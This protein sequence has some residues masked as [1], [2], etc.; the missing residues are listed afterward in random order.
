MSKR[1]TQKWNHQHIGFPYHWVHK[2]QYEDRKNKKR[3]TICKYTSSFGSSVHI[4]MQCR[5]NALTNYFVFRYFLCVVIC[6]YVLSYIFWCPLRMSKRATQKWNHQH[7][8]F[9]YHWVHKTQYEDRKNK[10]RNTICVGHHNTPASTKQHEPSYKQ[11]ETEHCFYVE[12]VMDIKCYIES[13]FLN[14]MESCFLNAMESCFLNAMES[15]FLNA[16]W[17]HV[18]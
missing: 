3:N 12:I 6:L 2:T 7:I 10:K 5:L 16:I 11:L 13:C 9:P 4:A 1:A 8:G 14:A 17:S 18:F 15:C